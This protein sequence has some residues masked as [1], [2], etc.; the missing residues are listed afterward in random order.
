MLT[1]CELFFLGAGVLPIMNVFGYFNSLCHWDRFKITPKGLPVDE[2]KS[3]WCPFIPLAQICLDW[4]VF[5][6]WLIASST[7]LVTTDE[8]STSAIL[9]G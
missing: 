4:L 2:L 5:F 7:L 1:T 8:L 3:V 6:A 9:D